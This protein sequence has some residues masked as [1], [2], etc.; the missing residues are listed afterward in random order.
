MAYPALQLVHG[1]WH[2]H[3]ATLTTL[4][5]LV[6]WF[7]WIDL[8]NLVILTGLEPF[9]KGSQIFLGA[10]GTLKYPQAHLDTS[11]SV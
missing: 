3:A 10:L 8:P 5:C 4:G 9:G 6:F 11:R 7:A 2:I 1:I